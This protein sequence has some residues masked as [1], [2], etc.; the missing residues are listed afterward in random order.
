MIA[1]FFNQTKP[2]NFVVLSIMML[3]VFMISSIAT[4]S[5][6]FSF[7]FLLKKGAFLFLTIL[8]IFVY[9]FIIRKNALTE[10]NSYALLFYILL[11]GFFPYILEN[12]KLLIANFILLFSFRRI[13]SLRTSIHVREK[14]FDSAFWIGIASMFYFWSILFFILIYSAIWAFNKGE[15][16]NIFIPIIGFTTPIFLTFV[17]Y[18]SGDNLIEFSKLW[19]INYDFSLSSYVFLKLLF[20]L[21]FLI[22]LSLISVYPT[23]KKSLIAKMD[24][25][26]TWTILMIHILLALSI[27]LISPQKTGSELMFL[28]FPLSILLANFIQIIKKYWLKE[29]IIYIFFITFFSI[30]F[31]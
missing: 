7:V 31:L 9:N 13:Y 22:I 14:I 21:V 24:F 1:N 2:I 5:G 3:L 29:M 8:M 27:V 15:K 12:N 23:T 11:I 25:K 10:N 20:P 30:Y 4:Y 6:D 28:F 16:R 19:S 18:L 17:Y 26:S